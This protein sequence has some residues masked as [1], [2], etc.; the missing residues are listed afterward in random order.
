MVDVLLIWR[1]VLASFRKPFNKEGNEFT[2]TS[3]V[4]TYIDLTSPKS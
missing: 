1:N 2:V 4:S 3:Y